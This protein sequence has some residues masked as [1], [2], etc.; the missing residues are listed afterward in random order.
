MRAQ[1]LYISVKLLGE[2]VAQQKAFFR[3]I[4]KLQTITEKELFAQ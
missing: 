2:K 1:D 4:K 3:K